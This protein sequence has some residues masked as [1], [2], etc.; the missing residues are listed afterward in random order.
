MGVT[1]EVPVRVVHR[2]WAA[3]AEEGEDAA[4]SRHEEYDV[5]GNGCIRSS[6][7]IFALWVAIGCIIAGAANPAPETQRDA[8]KDEFAFQQSF[9]TPRK[10][11]ESLIAAASNYDVPALLQIFGPAGKDFI[12]SADPVRDRSIAT[13]FAAKA[14]EKHVLAFDPK[15]GRKAILVVGAD[16]WPFPVPIIE[17]AGKWYF[18][19]K[20]GRR[21]ILLRR[22]GANELDVIKICHGF[23]EAQ[24]E[25]ASELHDDSG[26]NQY[27]Q[28]L[29]STPG[30]HD[31]LYW[32][33]P[34]GTPGGPISKAVAQAIQEGYSTDTPSGYHGYYFK[35][36]KGQGPAA[37]LGRLDY[38]IEG[39][40]IGGFALL[41]VPAEYRV[42]GVKTFMV[43]YDGV[44]YEKDLGP[45]TLNISK[46]IDLYNP[47]Q[48]WYRS[49]AHW[50][51]DSESIE[52]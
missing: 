31:G 51:D 28:K 47:D 35:V 16:G 37:P 26:V 15:G 4:E 11:A 10:A 33:N 19:S 8:S 2:V 44:V 9:T 32:E 3:A 29:I 27:A 17:R 43:S 42:T 5:I 38:V 41:A 23:V 49:A 12:S 20:Q 18:D 24:Q 45:D 36:L 7:A 30:K 14:Q 50:P 13:E 22:I 21:E 25:Y 46:S 52:D 1:P 40:M 34:D 6:G 39:A 48:T